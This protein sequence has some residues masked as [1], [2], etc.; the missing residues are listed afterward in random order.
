[1]K[2][3]LFLTLFF[4]GQAV[5]AD[6]RWFRINV[7]QPSIRTEFSPDPRFNR[8]DT[9]LQKTDHFNQADS[10]TFRQRYFID[11]SFAKFPQDRAPVLF[12]ICGEATCGGAN[13]S[14]YVNLLAKRIGAHRVAL[15]HRYYGYSQPFRTLDSQHL[16]Y[17]STAQALED[18]ADFQR[19]AMGTLG[20]R[21]KWIALGGSY[22]GSLSAFYRL[23]HPELVAGSLAS[24]AP[25]LSKANFEEYDRHVAQVAGPI[26]LNA[27]QSAIVEI[28]RKLSSRSESKALK[29]LFNSELILN[30]DD[31]LFVV[32]DMAAVAIQ[33]G[34]QK[35]FCDSLV[36]GLSKGKVVEAYARVGIDMFSR[37]GIAPVQ[38]SFQGAEST[39]PNDYLGWAGMRS[40]MYQSCTEYGYFQVAYSRPAESAR[41]SR[42]SLSYHHQVCKRLFGINQPVNEFR[43]NQ[44]YYQQLFSSGVKNVFFTN[45]NNDPWSLLSITS[46]NPDV[47]RNPALN[48]FSI[49]GAAHCEDLGSRSTPEL[50][51]ARTF[52]ESL[53]SKWLSE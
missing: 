48:F 25:V 30:D 34:F 2:F 11:S 1:M 5:Q 46:G 32:A 42:I 53:I 28:E 12:V 38:A 24:S 15:E 43:T 20:L 51:Q 22:P 37:F 10:R 29:R 44:I 23:K 6:P 50:V 21:G 47:F 18:L 31:F 45:G 8:E 52:F 39:D 40:W 9:Y 19:Y 14:D 4:M 3:M 41:S 26:C 49:P 36:D 17:L 33:Y 16:T 7:N 35:Q 13:S 27:I